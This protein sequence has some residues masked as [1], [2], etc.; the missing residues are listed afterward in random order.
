MSWAHF[1]FFGRLNELL[2]S[3]LKGKSTPYR[4]NGP[5]AIKHAVEVL[6]IPHTEVEY[7]LVNQISVGFDHLVQPGDI[8]FAYPAGFDGVMHQ[9]AVKPL[10]PPLRYPPRF[11]L[12]NHL[13]QL[14]SY[15][16]LL[17]FDSLYPNH[18]HDE[19]LAALSCQEERVLLTRDRRLLMRKIVVYGFCLTTRDPR[20]QLI[21]VLNRYQLD[22]YIHPWHRCLRCNGKLRPVPKEDV[23]SRLEPKTKLYYQE[24]HL[25][26]ECDQIYW[27]GSHFQP[28]QQLVTDI[29]QRQ[30][31]ARSTPTKPA[32]KRVGSA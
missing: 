17:G 13:G 28:L 14:T 15:L 11:V 32:T 18:F 5:V 19:E 22:P 26:Q 6:G 3:P 23:Y 2:L 9:P 30:R 31:R 27:K 25:C 21:H 8:V 1:S 7:L 12:D 4:L 24:F 20:Q 16:R 10:R 29:I